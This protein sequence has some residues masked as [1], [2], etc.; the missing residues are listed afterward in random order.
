MSTA[1]ETG[2]EFE[3]GIKCDE[4]GSLRRSDRSKRTNLLGGDR[5]VDRL[6]F[7]LL[8]LILYACLQS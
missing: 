4:N 6:T 2:E 5:D 1:R 7:A 8:S 3:A